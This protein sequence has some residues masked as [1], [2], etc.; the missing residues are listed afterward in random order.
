MKT[1]NYFVVFF[2]SLLWAC[3]LRAQVI[4]NAYARVT[5]VTS[6][7]LL[8]VS[9]VNETNHTFAVGEQVIVMQMQDDVIGT[10]TTNASTFGDLGSIANAGRYEV[11]NVSA[12]NRSAGTATSIG[13]SS[14]LVNTYNTGTNSRV[15][16]ISFR[17][18]NAAAFT[19]TAAITGLTW[20]GN[21]GGVIALQVGTDFTISHSITANGLGFRGGTVSANYYGGGT[22]CTTLTFASNSTNHGYKGEGIYATSTA[23]HA[24]GRAKILNGGGGGGQDINAGG[25]GGS[26]FTAGG[27]GGCGWNSTASG[28][29]TPCAA[30]LAGITLSANISASR[31]FMGGGGGGGQQNNT[32]GSSGG[33]G[34]G[35]ILIKANR[36]ITGGCATNPT[37]T[38]NGNNAANAS[39]DGAGGGGGGGSIVLQVSNYSVS[40]ACPLTIRA[41]GGNGGNI[42]TSTHAGGGAGGQG[43]VIYSVPQPTANVTTQ[44]NN[45]TA[46]C[47]DSG[48]GSS[49]GSAGGTSGGGI[50]PSSS[51]VLPVDLLYFIALSSPEGVQ[52]QWST[53]SEKNSSHFLVKRSRDGITWEI[54][55]RKTAQVNSKTV[56]YYTAYDYN[57]PSGTVYYKLTCVDLDLTEK[58][59]PVQLLERNGTDIGVALF[60]NPAVNSLNVAFNHKHTDFSI[61]VYDATGKEY[62][63]RV[64]EAY[65]GRLL[66]DVSMLG[67][68]IYVLGVE[69]L[70]TT[71]RTRF[72]VKK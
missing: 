37:I 55:D 10:N 67:E 72:I 38:A 19:T 51:G 52:L 54:I 29:T 32:N 11:A 48:C 27:Q 18:L 6:S 26:N 31:V 64:L 4:Y 24:N 40:A 57:P 35:I 71:T 13:L 9:N 22:A 7:T 50:I 36:I 43:V 63:P 14:A 65:D 60:P 62:L 69:S 47:N 28:C 61:R 44:A 2:C 16:V 25:G 33:N 49:A 8:T 59:S 34:G 5:A 45:G 3:T 39:N 30:G 17:L 70:G 56:T 66:L 20:N 46:G 21:T 42:T 58:N 12:V 15:Q 41:N 68:G 23:T 53:A 1:G